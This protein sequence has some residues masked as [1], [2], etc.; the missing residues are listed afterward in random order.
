[1][2]QLLWMHIVFI[3]HCLVQTIGGMNH[4][5]SEKNNQPTRRENAMRKCTEVR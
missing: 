4:S 1:M 5:S 2:G 3:V